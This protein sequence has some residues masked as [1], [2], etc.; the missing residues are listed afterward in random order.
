MNPFL[1]FKYNRNSFRVVK[2][3]YS[4]PPG[5][6]PTLFPYYISL[7]KFWQSTVLQPHNLKNIPK[8]GALKPNLLPKPTK[9]GN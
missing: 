2:L 9:S 8:K 7:F 1:F 3:A 5:T 6:K 4:Y